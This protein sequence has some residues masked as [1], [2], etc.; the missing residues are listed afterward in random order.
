MFAVPALVGS[1]QSVPG[2][3][4]AI[5]IAALAGCVATAPTP[6][7]PQ[8]AAAHY[9]EARVHDE[10]ATE[11]ERAAA[12]EQHAM[13]AQVI[14]GDRALSS[15][16]TSGGVPIT[17]VVPCWT[18]AAERDVHLRSAQRARREARAHRAIATALIKTERAAC[19]AIAPAER[20]HTPSWHRE[21]IIA[22]EAIRN[23]G[24]VRGARV[25][26]R[27]VP[28]LSAAWLRTAYECQQAVAAVEGF[29][30]T[31]ASYC[32]GTLDGVTIDVGERPDGFVVTFR[33]EANEIGA[34]VWGRA[35][36]L[37]PRSPGAAPGGS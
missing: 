2:M 3:R 8:S 17:H 28:G 13:R 16:S 29:D 26:F 31:Y 24:P 36:E 4:H 18:H 6:Q 7:R 20:D 12:A 22:I 19:A 5:S 30:P 37:A 32:P 14:C 34:A 23:G 25:V 33:A 15:Q 1:L 11:H 27:K 10:E 9:A 21:D 35:M